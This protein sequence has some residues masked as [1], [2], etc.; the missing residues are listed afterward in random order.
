[1]AS[2]HLP[3]IRTDGQTNVTLVYWYSTYYT[4]TVIFSLPQGVQGK[5]WAINS[6]SWQVNDT[7]HHNVLYTVADYS[8]MATRIQ[9]WIVCGHS[10]D[11]PVTLNSYQALTIRT[12]KK[13]ILDS[14][15]V[16]LVTMVAIKRLIEASRTTIRAT[17]SERPLSSDKL[18]DGWSQRL[19][20]SLYVM[21]VVLKLTHQ[22]FQPSIKLK[23][24]WKKF[25]VASLSLPSASLN[26]LP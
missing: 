11:D 8:G 19:S 2:G 20:T 3:L 21:G 1:M 26:V 23:Q 25:P 15:S 5:L 7:W 6:S 17:M 18:S 14:S 4:T 10:W 22:H 9:D 16:W 13:R 24:A 12:S